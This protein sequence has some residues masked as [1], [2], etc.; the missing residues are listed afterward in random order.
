[1]AMTPITDTELDRMRADRRRHCA[2]AAQARVRALEEVAL[3]DRF[4][5]TCAGPGASAGGGARQS[6]CVDSDTPPGP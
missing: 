5:A 6:A 1:M 2:A 3:W 4:C